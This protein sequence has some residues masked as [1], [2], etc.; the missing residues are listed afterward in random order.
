MIRDVSILQGLQ[1]FGGTDKQARA[2]QDGN[3][4]AESKWKV[5]EGL[6]R[7]TTMIGLV[8]AYELG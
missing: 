5:M 2:K 1:C 3:C 6:E 7:K 8:L 4:W